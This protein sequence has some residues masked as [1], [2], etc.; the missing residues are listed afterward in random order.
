MSTQELVRD[1]RTPKEALEAIARHLDAVN[2]RLDR[3]EKREPTD[4]WA[5]WEE[6]SEPE[7]EDKSE[8]I[9]ATV[10]A[11][12]KTSD[13]EER[14]ALEAQLR[15]LRDTGE[16]I[17]TG[18]TEGDR[19][20]ITQE[21]DSAVVEVEPP[22]DDQLEKRAMFAKA[23]M[24]SEHYN[25]T[26]EQ[27]DG[28]IKNGPLYLYYGD[29]DFVLE[30]PDLWKRQFVE[31]VDINSPAE[32]AEMGRDILKVAD[33]DNMQELTMENLKRDLGTL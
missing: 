11:L 14:G 26:P 7:K 17:E 6:E 23:V 19:P 13:P 16:N 29:R 30:L 10:E 2:V 9:Q 27:V 3:L 5:E 12:N 28:Y 25:F 15:L 31:D 32:A 20:R 1:A 18:Y 33:P 22:T 24:E 4:P 21:G 8:Q